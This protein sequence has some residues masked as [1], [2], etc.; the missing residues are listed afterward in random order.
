VHFLH[1]RKF[2]ANV[3]RAIIVGTFCAL[4]ADAGAQAGFDTGMGGAAMLAQV[5]EQP[6]FS[7]ARGTWLRVRGL[8]QIDSAAELTKEREALRE[9]RRRGYRIC[10]LVEWTED[11]W[12]RGVRKGGGKRVPVDLR[13]AWVRA[14]VLGK[15][16]GDCVDVWEIGNEPDI[17]FLEENP[18]TYA[19]YLKAC[20]LG[21]RA[22]AT[23]AAVDDENQP[24]VVMAPLAL[25]P[26]PYFE[27]LW[28][29]DG[30]AA[31]EGLNF[32]YYGYAEDFSDVYG[33]FRDA[34]ETSS[35]AK[36]VDN[37]KGV[38]GGARAMPVFITEYG[39]GLMDGVAR[40]TKEG[41]LR[42]WRWFRDVGEQLRG[43][44]VE[45]AMAFVLTP[46]LEQGL[47]EFGLLVESGA[48][49]ETDLAWDVRDFGGTASA[50]SAWADNTG[51][52]VG[53]WKISPALAWLLNEP[54]R[55]GAGGG[56]WRAGSINNDDAVVIDFVALEGLEQR[57]SF[58]GYFVSGL[59][60]EGRPNGWG[61][62]VVY[63]FSDTAVAGVLRLGAGVTS[64]GASECE[65]ELAAGERR[66][67]RVKIAV[68]N[69]VFR[70]VDSEMVF[71]AHSG[72]ASGTLRFA[73]RFWPDPTGMVAE[74]VVDF[75]IPEAAAGQT[76]KRL[77]ARWRA[78]EEP[79]LERQG[80]WMVSRGVSVIE[81]GTL[82]R[83]DVAAL[84]A[85]PS[86]PAM[87]ELPLPE[88]FALTPGQLLEFS[89]RLADGSV[90]T[91]AWLDVYFRTE[92]G[93]LYQVWPRLQAA[94][95]WRGYAEAAENFTMAF[96]GRAKL[97][98]RFFENKP[99]ALVFFLRPEK[100]PAV[101]E[102]EDAVITRRVAE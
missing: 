86:R 78:R 37:A 85:E 62:V 54:Q 22:G 31:T 41:R 48:Q 83:F 77:L 73:T 16:F 21:L 38:A 69:G 2:A 28:K 58:Q 19:A 64:E 23:V 55:A 33:Q 30:E 40:T 35:E 5:V 97:P 10:A 94:R 1:A 91:D 71:T 63:N 36:G 76:A 88:G 49:G 95:D 24:R 90:E 12:L 14:K 50:S 60:E 72:A 17:S 81:R 92:N 61:D 89:Y 7:A 3:R 51:K 96:Y 67:L 20:R 8:P 99:A 84:P 32:H 100:L 15:S 18:E 29:N 101:F 47:N 66:R 75:A 70:G 43:V 57:K 52:S 79:A 11:V 68:E 56:G 25:P 59:S 42:Q 102:I 26:G 9:L 65:L 93:N 74:R 53:V 4:V 87:V 6:E 44:S 80:R 13:E 27:R 46:Y 45:T 82:W 34:V 39:Y 98:W